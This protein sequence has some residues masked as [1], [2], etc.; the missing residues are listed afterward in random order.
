MKRIII[1]DGVCNLCDHSVQFILKHDPTES[2]LFAS[3][4]G[5]TG[6]R[7]QEKHRIRP[8]SDSFILIEGEKYY[9]ESTAALKVC[10]K[11]SGGWK[12]I[13]VLLII[14]RPIRDAAYRVIAR[15]RYNWFGKK[16]S[17]LVPKPEWKSRFLD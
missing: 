5:E 12:L 4:Q 7:L 2:F 10:R 17:C 9:M 3:L 15:N 16:E 8:D 13:S 11:L 1:F 6:K 14:P